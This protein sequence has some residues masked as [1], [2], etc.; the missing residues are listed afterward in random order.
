MSLICRMEKIIGLSKIARVVDMFSRRLQVQENL[1]R[2]IAEALFSVT[3]AHGVGVIIEAQHF[4]HDDARRGK[5]KL[6]HM[7]IVCDAWNLSQWIKRRAR[8]F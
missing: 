7:S 5:T 2:K 8:S 6:H 3:G 4:V 1:T